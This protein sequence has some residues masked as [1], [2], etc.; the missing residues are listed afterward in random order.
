MTAGFIKT[1]IAGSVGWLEYDRP[2]VNAFDWTMLR[3][4]APAF[5][6]LHAAR[7]V[8]VI[9]FAAAHPKY[10]SSGADLSV[11]AKIDGP[12]MREWVDLCHGVVA[13]MRG[14]NKPILAAINGVAVGGGLEMTLHADIRFAAAD[15][16]L[17]QPEIR[18]GMLPPVGATQALARLLGRSR[19]I[20]MLYDGEMMSAEEARA[21]GLVDIVVPP[22][23]LHAAVQ[24]YA[25]KLAAKPALALAAIRR[26]IT[27]GGGTSFDEGLKIERDW[28]VRLAESADF[29]EGVTAFLEKRAPKWTGG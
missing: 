28:A 26:T 10:F 18:I 3:E 13:R 16:K 22:A 29:K 12:G 11:F 6:T 17:G 25:E 8:R 21:L 23:D 4:V 9:V 24:A 1:R 7:A 2:P 15:A 20:R 19:A 5:D 14:S 27:E